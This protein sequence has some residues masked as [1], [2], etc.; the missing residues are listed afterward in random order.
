[1]LEAKMIEDCAKS[2][3][4][5]M[6]QRA[7]ASSLGD[8]GTTSTRRLLIDLISTLNASFPDYDFSTAT[9]DS[10]VAQDPD[11]VLKKVNSHLAEMTT[12]NPTFLQEMWQ[13][14]NAVRVA[15]LLYCPGACISL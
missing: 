3:V 2:E 4:T 14:I 9:P 1:M 13:E 12:V 11:V 7:R 8:L 5:P 10:F 6:P 15:A